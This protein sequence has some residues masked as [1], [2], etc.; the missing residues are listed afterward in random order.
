MENE[1]IMENN[2]VLEVAEDYVTSGSGSALKI[3]GG[4]AAVAGLAY[5]GYKLIKKFRAKK[6][7]EEAAEVILTENEDRDVDEN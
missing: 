3:V 2:E 4:I 6:R 5:G 7:E 1:K